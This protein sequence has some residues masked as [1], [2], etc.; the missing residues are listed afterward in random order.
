MRYKV[1]KPLKCGLEPQFSKNKSF[2]DKAS[3]KNQRTLMSSTKN[4][5]KRKRNRWIYLPSW[6]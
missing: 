3:C 2:K 6:M 4:A 1:A 5:Y